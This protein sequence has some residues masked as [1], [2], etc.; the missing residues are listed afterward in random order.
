MSHPSQ[1]DDGTCSKLA[2]SIDALGVDTREAVIA[3]TDFSVPEE[4]VG[5]VESAQM[6]V[7]EEGV[8]F[9]ALLKHSDTG[10]TTAEI[11]SSMIEAAPASVT[12]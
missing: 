1:P 6:I 2:E 12:K 8:A 3:P 10:V 4:C 7:R 11:P 5:A 9:R